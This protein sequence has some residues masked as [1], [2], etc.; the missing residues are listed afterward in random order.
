MYPDLTIRCTLVCPSKKASNHAKMIEKTQAEIPYSMLEYTAALKRPILE[1]WAVP[2]HLVA[3]VLDALDPFGF[4]PDG[5]ELKTRAEKL[6]ENAIVFRRTP[7]G[8]TFTVGVEKVVI[9]AENLDWSDADQFMRAARAGLDAVLQ[10]GKADIRLQHLVLGIHIQLKTRPRQEVTAPLLSPE[11]LKLLD[12]ELKMPGVILQ[13][14][15]CSIVIDGSLAFANGLFVR[16]NREH[17]PIAAFEQMAEVL[18][19]D[20][21]QLFD[22]LGLEG[23]L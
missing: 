21:K 11:T 23:E 9:V 17:A 22:L 7:A 1:A 6:T 4:K 18:R 13:R 12:G 10:K 5:V 20:E 3:V 16:I 19:N 15:K 14:E 2:A 8:V